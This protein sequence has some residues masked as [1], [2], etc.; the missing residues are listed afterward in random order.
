MDSIATNRDQAI[1]FTSVHL[2]D[3]FW[4]PRQEAV[5]R[6]TIPYLYQQCEKAGMIAAL[7][8]R[9]TP[10]PLPIGFQVTPIGTKPATPVM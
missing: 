3:Q 4:A 9:S 6:T 10:D 5:R 1:P 2:D 8:I 7:D